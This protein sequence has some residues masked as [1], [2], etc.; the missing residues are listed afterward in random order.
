MCVTSDGRKVAP[1]TFRIAMEL[2]ITEPLRMTE[3]TM[4]QMFL[5]GTGV[6][7]KQRK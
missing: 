5:V 4:Q 7:D 6:Y 3:V 2:G 1:F